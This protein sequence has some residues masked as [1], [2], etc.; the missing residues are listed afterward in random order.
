MDAQHARAQPAR[1][2]TDELERLGGE[3]GGRVTALEDEIRRGE[4]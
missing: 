2:V 1:L 3:L 4:G